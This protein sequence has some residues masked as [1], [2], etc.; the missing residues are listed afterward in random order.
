M[1]ELSVNDCEM[2]SGGMLS[3]QQIGLLKGMT[4]II[5][6]GALCDPIIMAVGVY[7]MVTA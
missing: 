2:V 1:Q 4:E 3:V 6:G 7:D 5:I